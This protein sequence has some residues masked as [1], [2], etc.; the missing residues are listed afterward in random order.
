MSK[1]QARI[2]R[3][4]LL[5]VSLVKVGS[6]ECWLPSH[7]SSPFSLVQKRANHLTKKTELFFSFCYNI[8]GP[9]RYLKWANVDFW[10]EFVK[11]YE[12]SINRCIAKSFEFLQITHCFIKLTALRKN[13]PISLFHGWAF[14]LRVVRR[15]LIVCFGF[16]FSF[17]AGKAFSSVLLW[18]TM[19]N[20]ALFQKILPIFLRPSIENWRSLWN[21]SSQYLTIM[22]VSTIHKIELTQG[23]Q[24]RPFFGLRPQVPRILNAKNSLNKCA[25]N[26]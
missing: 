19:N 9:L 15:S 11:E 8:A 26:L 12:E 18:Y 24:H 2:L 25:R 13:N 3:S 14:C 17:G 23:I 6:S 20:S 1:I 16:S 5:R 7:E 22:G 21:S 4:G 10:A